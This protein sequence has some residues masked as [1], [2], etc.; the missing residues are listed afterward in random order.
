MV[1]GGMVEGGMVEGGMVEGGEHD[2]P[3][4]ISM[5]HGPL[6]ISLQ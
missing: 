2:P 4:L 6:G 5:P 1:E 3:I